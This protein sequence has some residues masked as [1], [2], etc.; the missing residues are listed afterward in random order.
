MPNLM[1]LLRGKSAAA[2]L[3]TAA[4]A[5]EHPLGVPA[6]YEVWGGLESANRALWVAVWFSV[7]VS[8]LLLALLRL[9]MSRPP[10]VIR[11]DGTGQAQFMA[12]PSRQPP[13]SEAEVKNFLTLFERFFTELNAYTYESDLKLAFSMMTPDFQSQAGNLM[14]RDGVIDKLKGADRKTT[15]T[16]TEIRI[17]SDTPQVI[18]CQVK[19][20]RELGSY[21]PDAPTQEVVFEDDVVLKKVPRSETAPNGL[22]VEAWTES[23]FKKQ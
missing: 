23:L 5:E 1:E 8:L 17:V 22:L 15:L 13:V 20:Y 11:V 12:D 19:G 21:K 2:A 3:A 4:K 6:Y 10:I 7:T 14:K 9:Q 16:L 18:E